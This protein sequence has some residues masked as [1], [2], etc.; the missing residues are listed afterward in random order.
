MS[1]DSN[2]RRHNITN[3]IRDYPT[4][5]HPNN[6]IIA[7]RRLLKLPK[8]TRN[9]NVIQK[10]EGLK[11]FAQ[12][13]EIGV[14]SYGRV[15]KAVRIS[16]GIVYAIKEMNI[17]HMTGPERIESLNEI[18]ILASVNHNNIIRFYDA[19]LQNNNLYVVTEFAPNGDLGKLLEKKSRTR[20]LL[21][22]NTIWTYFIQICLAVKELHSRN[23]LHRDLKPQNVFLAQSSNIKLGDVGSSRLLKNTMTRTQCGTPYY[24]SP[25][26]WKNQSYG[27]KTDIWALGTILYNMA[28]LHPPF[29]STNMTDLA[30]K[31]CHQ[32]P[33]RLFHYSNDL[34]KMISWL[35]NKQPS[36]R[37][38]IDELLRSP[39]IHNRMRL[40]DN[41]NENNSEFNLIGTISPCNNI[42]ELQRRLPD[43]C[44]EQNK[45]PKPIILPFIKK[46]KKSHEIHVRK[47]TKVSYD[48]IISIGDAYNNSFQLEDANINRN[49]IYVFDM[50][51]NLTLMKATSM[52][53]PKLN[54]FALFR[55][56]D[57]KTQTTRLHN[58]YIPH[59][60]SEN[61]NEIIL[62]LKK[63]YD[64]KLKE[65]NNIMYSGK[66]I[67][68]V[69]RF[70][71]PGFKHKHY[72]HNFINKISNRYPKTDFHL[73]TC[74]YTRTT[75]IKHTNITM[76]TT[77]DY[78]DYLKKNI[79]KTK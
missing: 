10:E 24:M 34:I 16:D 39:T 37:P 75:N 3:N 53:H 26:I 14:G 9:R 41:I 42:Q 35:M 79:I 51:S 28:A 63:Y 49:I 21:N 4:P 17:G 12:L 55:E 77:N 66:K 33:P 59:M 48:H 76:N 56:Y 60:R 70:T 22:E 58:L 72:V 1:F 73:L 30:N 65:L 45:I 38:T 40:I 8:I 36:L 67:L 44:Y 78:I 68:F 54:T 2:G 19:F 25:E 52:I 74:N 64:M 43:P 5:S 61:D 50:I 46:K 6:T 20:T 71:K 31:V 13:K 69:H 15:Y 23:I 62:R 18:R 27:K 7:P 57:I 29:R 47:T 11:A 32:Q